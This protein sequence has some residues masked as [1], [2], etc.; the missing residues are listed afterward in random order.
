M[1]QNPVYT[2]Q[3]QKRAVENAFPAVITLFDHILPQSSPLKGGAS[4]IDNQKISDNDGLLSFRPKKNQ[5]LHYHDDECSGL[6]LAQRRDNVNQRVRHEAEDLAGDPP[7]GPFAPHH[8][9]HPVLPPQVAVGHDDYTKL[10][11]YYILCAN[12]TDECRKR[13]RYV[14]DPLPEEFLLLHEK[15][16]PLLIMREELQA[17]PRTKI[18]RRSRVR[19]RLAIKD[20]PLW[21]DAVDKFYLRRKSENPTSQ[22]STSTRRQ[23]LITPLLAVESARGSLQGSSPNDHFEGHSVTCTSSGIPPAYILPLLPLT[24]LP[25]RYADPMIVDSHGPKAGP[26]NQPVEVIEVFDSDD[27]NNV[28]ILVV[29][30]FWTQNNAPYTSFVLSHFK[31]TR[32]CIHDYATKLESGGVDLSCDIEIYNP[33]TKAWHRVQMNDRVVLGHAQL[34]M[35]LMRYRGIEGLCGF[36]EVCMAAS[37]GQG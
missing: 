15:L 24:P 27:E 14:T 32:F 23:R 31:R 25:I 16:T 20:S 35:F 19:R 5:L 30:I 22:A 26:S 7:R 9:G 33:D 28:P 36:T 6:P 29:V 18:T 12:P 17:T 2:A 11:R 13:I 1:E 8:K 21:A 34:S 4:L 10:G 37:G 3:F